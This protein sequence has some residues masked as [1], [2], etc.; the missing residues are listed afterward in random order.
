[1][2]RISQLPN[3][4]SPAD[5]DELPLVDVSTTTTKKLTLS[6][7][8]TWL[9]SLAAWVT[10]AMLADKAVTTRKF[11]PTTINSTTDGFVVQGV[12]FTTTSTSY[13]AVPGC[14]MNYTAGP[15]NERLFIRMDT[16]CYATPSTGEVALYVNGVGEVTTLY[17]DPATPWARAG[18]NYII[19]VAANATITLV[20]RI[21][22]A[23]G[24]TCHITNEQPY[25]MPT[26][27]G[28]SV[29]NQ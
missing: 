6:T 29:N 10:T 15:T 23:G 18:Q 3:L 11:K 27:R 9:Q 24:T 5:A 4:T 19:D 17:V 12:R 7:L 20:I 8:V 1:M 28:F 14:S 22:A 21:K 2:P 13:V 26:L 25:W 16:M